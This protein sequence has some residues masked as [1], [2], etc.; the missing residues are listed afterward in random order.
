MPK[1][2]VKMR[3]VWTQDVEIEADSKEDAIQR[4][5]EGEGEYVQNNNS[6]EYSHTS[7][8]ENWTVEMLE[9]DQ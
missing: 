1:F 7:D 4:V 6:P 3:E 9:D 8:I 2:I 5:S